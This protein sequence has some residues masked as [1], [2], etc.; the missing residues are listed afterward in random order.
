MSSPA[1]GNPAW[2]GPSSKA[3]FCEEDYVVTRYVAEF[4]NS[5]TN[6][7]YVFYAVYGLLQLRKKSNRDFFR[8]LPYWGL[9]AVGICSASFHVSLQ[10]HT[11]M[12]DDLSMLFTT[13]P[14]LHQVLTV[15]A[16]RHD[17]VLIGCALYLA[18]AVF[19]VYHTITD[20]LL[21]H[22]LFF[23][24]SIA[25]IGIR[26]FQLVQLRTPKH[27]AI[28]RQIWGMVRFGA[29]IFHLGYLVWVVDG[30]AC[31][32]LRQTRAT[33]GLPWAWALE[34]HGWWHI[35]TGIGAYTFIAVID[36]LVSGTD[37]ADLQKSF[38]WPTPWAA[39]SIFA[40]SQLQTLKSE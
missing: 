11:Q 27:S 20:E 5:L 6:L 33:V 30:W 32:W 28:R 15:N 14:I 29:F 37:H 21:V 13:T 4:I 23:V 10:Y 39:Q 3:N 2:G 24:G 38:A 34:L 40:G 1:L 7:T 12:L 19:L 25:V 31:D 8:A 36:H 18:L 9:M 35:F 22:V 16:S 17:S 26:T